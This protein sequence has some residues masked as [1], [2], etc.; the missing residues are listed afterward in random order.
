MVL[1]WVGLGYRLVEVQ[2]IDAEQWSISGVEQVLHNE[3]L[4]A[5]RGTIYDR[6]GVELAV[7][8]DAVT[9]VADPSLVTEP[10]RTARLVAPVLGLGV[11]AVT[12]VLS[13]DGRFAYVARAIPTET[14]D[15]LDRVIDENDLTGLTFV[16]EPKRTYPA[17]SLASQL[18]GIVMSDTEEG[19]EGLELALDEELT[20]TDG[21]QVIERGVRDPDPAG[22]VRR[23]AGRPRVG[24][25]ADHRP[26]DPVRRRAAPRPGAA[27]DRRPGGDGDRAPRRHRGTPGGGQQPR[28][29]PQPTHRHL[30]GDGAQ[31]GGQRRVRAR[32]RRSRW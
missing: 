7:T 25:G 17:G 5:P 27:D 13:G 16:T 19:L 14:A 31:P 11:A 18:V 2:A 15:E 29:R 32:A 23:G 26:R 24:R 10:R 22:D 20:G 12:D 1:A 3:A 4:P 28:V 9:V 30:G 8:V 6:D 21:T